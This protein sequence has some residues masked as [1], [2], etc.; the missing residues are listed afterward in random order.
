M[1]KRK[2]LGYLLLMLAIAAVY[3]M[4]VA[5]RVEADP[6]L[7]TTT[8]TASTVTQTPD[9][10]E[11][12]HLTNVERLNTGLPALSLDPE[13]NRSAAAKCADMARYGYWSHANPNGTGQWATFPAGYSQAGENL[14]KGFTDET[15]IM[16][17]WMDSPTH[18]EN[19]LGSYDEVGFASCIGKTQGL[20]TVQHFTQH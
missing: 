18:R 13:L 8:P 1:S 19:I 14:A 15:V 9:V 4:L 20:I 10:T 6:R 3:G 2:L 5:L 7:P 17:A 11:L 16:D 12:W